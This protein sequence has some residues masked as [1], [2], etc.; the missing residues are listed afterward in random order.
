MA[1]VDKTHMTG[2]TNYWK[3]SK[4]D[5][6]PRI[7]LRGKQIGRLYVIDFHHKSKRTYY[8]ECKCDCGNVCIKSSAYLLS[9]KYA[10]HP[11]C[12]CWHRELSIASSTKHSHGHRN[13]RTYKTWVEM[14]MR[15][16]N[17]T[18]HAYKDYGAR[19]ITVCDRW[20]NSFEEFLSDMGERPHGKSLDRIDNN[21][22]YCPENCRWA[23]PKEQCNNRRSNFLMTLNGETKSLTEW[24]RYL[25][26]PYA[27]MH[28]HCV[29]KKKS[30]EDFLKFYKK[31][32]NK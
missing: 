19:G 15:C 4:S 29:L 12:G 23:T 16:L 14:K 7:D 24:G 13:N 3:I 2:K 28:Y 31:K 11:S 18:N 25:D 22:G 32:Y 10:P 30:L 9:R 5:F 6:I 1:Y 21:K 8:Y 27:R 20:N 26:I 17:P